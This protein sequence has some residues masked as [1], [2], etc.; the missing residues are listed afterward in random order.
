MRV[1][2]V[3]A[4]TAN[5]SGLLQW[6]YCNQFEWMLNA[7]T[8]QPHFQQFVTDGA[9]SSLSVIAIRALGQSI[10]GG[11]GPLLLAGG[12]DEL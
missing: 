3:P 4:S 7:H 11:T 1:V 10:V 9:V 5:G 6:V 8:L 2:L 12:T